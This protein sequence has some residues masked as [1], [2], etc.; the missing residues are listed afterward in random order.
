MKKILQQLYA[1]WKK[2]K[3]TILAFL[4][5]VILSA[6]IITW[7][8][9][10]SASQEVT[11]DFLD[12]VIEYNKHTVLEID[13]KIKLISAEAT[14]IEK[15]EFVSSIADWVKLNFM[16]L[17]GGTLILW[18]A[19]WE[20]ELIIKSKSDIECRAKTNSSWKFSCM[21][22]TEILTQNDVLVTY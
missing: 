15:D 17:W 14:I 18:R 10:V 6:C 20:T 4:S 5:G 22:A 21:F 2:W 19:K 16:N 12:E 13:K 7:A 8:N 11:N 9:Y 1:F 3:Q